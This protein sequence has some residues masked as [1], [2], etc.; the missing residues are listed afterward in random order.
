MLGLYIHIPFCRQKCPYC[1]FYS[2]PANA[3][4]VQAYFEALHTHL[5]QWAKE[6]TRTV[7]TIYFG[8][9]TPGLFP[10]QIANTV[11]H[12]KS[13]FDVDENCEISMEANPGA[14]DAEG[15]AAVRKAGVNRL[16]FGVQSASEK[17]LAA[18]GRIHTAAQAKESIA[19]AKAA[20]FDNI[21]VDFMLATPGQDMGAVEDMRAFLRECDPAHVSAYMLKVEPDT[22]FGK[23]GNK[24]VLPDEDTVADLYE[25]TCEMLEELG[26]S[27]YE[28]S[29]FA[30][31]G[32]ACRHNL[33]YWDFED[34]LGVGPGAHSMYKGRRVYYPSD[35][36]AFIPGGIDTVVFDGIPDT[37]EYIMLQL[38][39]SEG[40]D[41]ALLVDGEQV[42]QRAQKFNKYGLC[43]IDGTRVALTV[44]GFLVSNMVI[45]QL[46]YG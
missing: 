39:K 33:K 37:D 7:N 22:P 16:S 17:D 42:L 23:M 15:L 25:A 13:C 12:I 31:E 46:L 18:L 2:S 10:A 36:D 5:S 26:Y 43:T 27:Q 40:L 1:N 30:K 45:A 35:T 44:K 28:V 4:K 19:V 38:R 20:G 21:S 29:N 11:A 6:E 14:I 8:G 41:T 3:E 34:Y 32:Y 24:L 9:G